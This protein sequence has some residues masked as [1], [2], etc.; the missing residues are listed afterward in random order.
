MACNLAKPTDTIIA[1]YIPKLYRIKPIGNCITRAEYDDMVTNCKEQIER[2]SE[3]YKAAG[4]NLY[5]DC[6][7]SFPEML[8]NSFLKNLKFSKNESLYSTSHLSLNDRQRRRNN[9][10]ANQ[11]SDEVSSRILKT[12]IKLK[13]SFL[14]LGAS[15]E[16]I[17]TLMSAD[18]PRL[19]RDF[20]RADSSL[21]NNIQAQEDT[22]VDGSLLS[23]DDFNYRLLAGGTKNLDTD[24]E[25]GYYDNDSF[26]KEDRAK[27]EED[28]RYSQECT[29]SR[30]DV[31]SIPLTFETRSDYLNYIERKIK[32]SEFLIQNYLLSVERDDVGTSSRFSFVFSNF[33]N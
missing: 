8:H 23:D 25:Q 27:T 21:V 32:V 17:S 6:I 9:F 11:L 5:V 20:D 4:Y 14:V 18:L 15:G 30:V 28:E 12:A 29:L 3:H 33:N 22:I 10:F 1:V 2:L 19:P 16:I 13:A 24:S 7:P 26:I 31:T